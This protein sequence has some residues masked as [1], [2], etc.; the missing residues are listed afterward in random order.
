M[1]KLN[2]F[3]DIDDVIFDFQKAYATKFN[4]KQQK[5]WSKSKLMSRRLN[6]LSNDKDFWIALPV[7]NKPNFLPKGFVSARG[8]YK[9]WTVESLKRNKIP[10]RS[11]IFQ[12]PWGKSKLEVLKELNCDIFVDD[13]VETFK[14]LNKNGVF[15]LLMDASHNQKV[16]TKYRV[17]DLDIE[18]I[19]E[20]YD[21]LCSN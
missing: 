10:G 7:K 12:V 17:Y 6:I 21:S 5:S 19:M 16:K 20:K 2:V 11:R 3:L 4:T 8:I 14:E 15:C 18:K 13:K 9:T 1:R